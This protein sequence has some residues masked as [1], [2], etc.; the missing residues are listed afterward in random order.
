NDLLN[1]VMFAESLFYIL[2]ILGLFLLRR[3][4]PEMERP[5]KVIAYPVLP[6]LYIALAIFFDVWC[7]G[8]S[9]STPAAD[10][11]WYCWGC[12]CSTSGASWARPSPPPLEPIEECFYE[13]E[14]ICAQG[15]ARDAERNRRR[16]GGAEA[17]SRPAE[18]GDAGHRGHHRHRHFR[19][20]RHGGGP[21][22]WTGGGHFLCHRRRRLGVCRTLLCRVLGADSDC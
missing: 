13:H 14:F 3:K 8:S 16:A 2:T 5:Y 9:R 6:A 17:R 12:R 10:C 11:C 1:Y 20:H 21:K 22:R 7:C 19:P 18:L 15:F 4:R